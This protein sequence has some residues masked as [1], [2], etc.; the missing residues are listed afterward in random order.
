MLNLNL[1]QKN[2]KWA[3]RSHAKISEQ[4]NEI[5]KMGGETNYGKGLR[6]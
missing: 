5:Y 4:T 6:S 3:H 2:K 1:H